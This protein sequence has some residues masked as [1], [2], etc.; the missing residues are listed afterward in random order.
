MLKK[1]GYDPFTMKIGT[2]DLHWV[3]MCQK[4]IMEFL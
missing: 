1:C 2:H 4:R 3:C